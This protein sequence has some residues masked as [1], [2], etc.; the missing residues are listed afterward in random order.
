MNPKV[1]LS[2]PL[3]YVETSSP[4]DIKEGVQKS[5]SKSSQSREKSPEPK[6]MET[7]QSVG[8]ERCNECGIIYH[9]IRKHKCR[10]RIAVSLIPQALKL[11]NISIKRK[12]NN[13]FYRFFF[14]YK[15]C[16]EHSREKARESKYSSSS[17]LSRKCLRRNYSTRFQTRMG[18]STQ[19][20][21]ERKR[22][23]G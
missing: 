8:Y 10:K 5:H 7:L 17:Q 4:S 18:S 1:R 12:K 11:G 13:N 23:F 22:R 15:R 9:S 2:M 6:Y 14:I 20:S 21:R 16:S 3:T 19:K